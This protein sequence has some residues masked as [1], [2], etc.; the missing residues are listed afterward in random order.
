[1]EIVGGE[2]TT[3]RLLAYVALTMNFGWR[4][5]ALPDRATSTHSK[6]LDPY[7][8]GSLTTLDPR[9]SVDTG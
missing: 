8:F 2:V 6:P 5:Y 4:K 9:V 7:S 3:Y 1:M